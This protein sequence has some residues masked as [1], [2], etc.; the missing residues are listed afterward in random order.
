M[1]V[2]TVP[3]LSRTSPVVS[4]AASGSAFWIWIRPQRPC[5]VAGLLVLL[6]ITAH[7][8]LAGVGRDTLPGVMKPFGDCTWMSPP[9]GT[10]AAPPAPPTS[11]K[12]TGHVT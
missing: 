11:R 5:P 4:I 2:L 9:G 3:C 1:V 10:V 8:C 6:I 12:G 7:H